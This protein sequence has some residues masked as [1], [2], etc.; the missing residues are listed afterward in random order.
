[1][2]G[3]SFL[4]VKLKGHDLVDRV[5]QMVVPIVLCSKS[6]VSGSCLGSIVDFVDRWPWY[7]YVDKYI[8]TLCLPRLD[9]EVVKYT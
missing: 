1:M 3:S 9:I 5:G 8:C 7:V 2:F 6:D 4:C